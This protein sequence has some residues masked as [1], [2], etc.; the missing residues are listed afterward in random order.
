VGIRHKERVDGR[1][2]HNY[3]PE[4]ETHDVIY[5]HT[6]AEAC[7]AHDKLL[8]TYGDKPMSKEVQEFID[9]A[10]NNGFRLS[11]LEDSLR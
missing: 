8:G 9:W 5:V 10:A 4:G 6:T 11:D 1:F 3:I 2:T 7:Y